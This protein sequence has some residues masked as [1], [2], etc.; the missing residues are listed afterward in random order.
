[1]SFDKEIA[2]EA[3]KLFILKVIK[4]TFRKSKQTSRLNTYVVRSIRP[5]ICVASFLDR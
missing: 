3:N 4:L 1:M 5:E 2:I